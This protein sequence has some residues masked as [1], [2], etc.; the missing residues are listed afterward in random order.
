MLDG[1]QTSSPVGRAL[2]QLV[3]VA[4]SALLQAQLLFFR[5]SS[6]AASASCRQCS[7]AGYYM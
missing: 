6:V 2:L 3:L 7:V 1:S 5:K 4:G